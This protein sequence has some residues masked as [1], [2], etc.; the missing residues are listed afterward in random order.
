MRIA[1]PTW[2][3]RVSPVFDVARTLVLADVTD[4]RVTGRGEVQIMNTDPLARARELAQLGAEVLICGAISMPTDMALHSAGIRVIPHTCGLV[5]EVLGAFVGGQWTNNAFLMPG[6][7]GRGMGR[8]LRCRGGRGR[9][10][11]R[12]GYYA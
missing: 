11:N 7:R 1:I 10:G 6:C 8:R 3:G 12:G 2:Q 4:G 5:D 9:R